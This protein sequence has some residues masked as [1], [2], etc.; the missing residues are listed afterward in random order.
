MVDRALGPN[1]ICLGRKTA[2]TLTP[3]EHLTE[4]PAHAQAVPHSALSA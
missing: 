4:G 3:E 2:V 1:C